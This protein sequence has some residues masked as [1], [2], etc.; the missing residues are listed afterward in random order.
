LVA[1][2]GVT[3]EEVFPGT[4]A[5]GYAVS[6]TTVAAWS[7]ICWQNSCPVP[8]EYLV[9]RTGGQFSVAIPY[10]PP[11]LYFANA[12]PI[13]ALD[14]GNVAFLASFRPTEN[15]QHRGIFVESNGVVNKLLDTSTG[16][17]DSD[18]IGLL[19]YENGLVAFAGGGGSATPGIYMIDGQGSYTNILGL[20][21]RVPD[22]GQVYFFPY[23]RNSASFDSGKLV[24]E[25]VANDRFGLYAYDVSDPAFEVTKVIVPGDVLD[26][27]EVANAYLTTDAGEG[28]SFAFSAR[29]VDGQAS[30][31]RADL[32]RRH[33]VLVTHGWNP[34]SVANNDWISTVADGIAGLIIDVNGGLQDQSGSVQTAANGL[35]VSRITL[36]RSIH[37][38]CDLSVDPIA[39]VWSRFGGRWCA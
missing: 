36:A 28:G 6:S 24:I 23:G 19:G 22:V 15:E 18:N 29:F 16:L 34:T 9:K 26:G 13:A 32:R 38:L 39:W 5:S 7:V 30:V 1:Y 35:T 8:N 25:G 14:G 31:Y 21:M 33:L 12:A 11:P 2:D 4:H 20:E 10:G 3:Q 37:R 17:F 27:R